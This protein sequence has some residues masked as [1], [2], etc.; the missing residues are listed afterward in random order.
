MTFDIEIVL[1]NEKDAAVE[2]AVH[3]RDPHK[4]DEED[5]RDVLRQILLALN[6]V[7]NPGAPDPVVALR[8]FSWIVEPFDERRVVIA[9]EIPMG[10]AIAGPFAI[11]RTA[12]DALV[13]RAI[14]TTGGPPV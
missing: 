9:L 7:G 14:A 4:W 13:T 5:V 1:R 6:R 3:P 11:G 12:L 10:A 8:G 2:R